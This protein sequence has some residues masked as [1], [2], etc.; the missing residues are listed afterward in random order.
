[1]ATTSD[2][3]RLARWRPARRVR[4]G[5]GRGLR[6]GRSQASAD[7]ASG[8]NELPVQRAVADSLRPGAVFVDIG[9]NVGFFSLIAARVV[10]DGGRVVALEPVPENVAAIRANARRNR[11]RVDVLE[12]AAGAT[13]GPTSLVLTRH[14]GG[15]VL[16][17][18]DAPPDA[19]GRI[20]VEG[21]TVDDLVAAGRLPR[22]SVVKIDVEGAEEA[23]LQGMTET[24]T[25]VGPTLIVE[26]DG[27]DDAALARRRA[28]IVARLDDAGYEVSDLEPSYPGMAWKVAHLLARPAGAP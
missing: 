15:A 1:M 24:L 23:V 12:V 6:I 11:L 27:P 28:G 16:A 8:T 21:A 25:S 20:E 5:V 4:G 3:G 19:T 17:S 2:L 9:A 13:N 18:A 7:Y 26:V 10:G 14:P 22:P